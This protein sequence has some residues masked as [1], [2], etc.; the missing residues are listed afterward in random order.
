MKFIMG[1]RFI[2]LI[3]RVDHILPLLR[4]GVSVSQSGLNLLVPELFP[5][6][7]NVFFVGPD[8]RHA[9]LYRVERQVVLVAGPFV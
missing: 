1:V 2:I 7:L 6:I 4:T 5:S 8:C 3:F 9:M